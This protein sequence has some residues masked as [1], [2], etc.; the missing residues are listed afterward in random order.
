MSPR[1]G[2]RKYGRR[3]YLAG[4]QLA[5]RIGGAPREPLTVRPT[6]WRIGMLKAIHGGAIRAGQGQYEGQWRWAGLT[7]TVRVLEVIAAGWVRITAD[8]R[9]LEL[10]ADG[11][12]V[13]GIEAEQ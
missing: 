10:T 12:V 4:A 8:R 2:A 6:E 9:H 1:P 5:P 3:G 11:R 7:V 13:A